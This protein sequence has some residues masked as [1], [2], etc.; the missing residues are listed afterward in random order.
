M[1]CIERGGAIRL[2]PPP[3]SSLARS[4]KTSAQ[5]PAQGQSHDKDGGLTDANLRQNVQKL[6]VKRRKN[7][8]PLNSV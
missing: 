3:P 4:R 8:T 6:P 1:S 5:T 2:N 7:T